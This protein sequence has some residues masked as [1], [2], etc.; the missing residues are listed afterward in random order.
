MEKVSGTTCNVPIGHIDGTN[1]LPTLADCI[2]LV[3]IKLKG[4][5]E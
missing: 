2:G 3:I 4:K 5:L 1:V